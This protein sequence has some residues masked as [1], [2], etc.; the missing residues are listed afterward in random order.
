MPVETAVEIGLV[1]VVATSVWWKRL[2]EHPA[3]K[4]GMF[5]LINLAIFLDVI[6]RKGIRD[7]GASLS[8]AI[9]VTLAFLFLNTLRTKGNRN[10]DQK[11]QPGSGKSNK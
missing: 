11:E 10:L 2:G 6:F 8:G 7:F 3:F 1:V 9:T 5:F 4:I